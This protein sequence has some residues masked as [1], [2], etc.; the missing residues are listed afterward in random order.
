MKNL[1]WSWSGVIIVLDAST[2]FGT[3]LIAI[4]Q[5]ILNELQVTQH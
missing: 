1:E 5:V 2:S 3:M 4:E